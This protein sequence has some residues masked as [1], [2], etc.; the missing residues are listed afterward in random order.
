M[1][2]Q[3]CNEKSLVGTCIQSLSNLLNRADTLHIDNFDVVKRLV[4]AISLASLNC[5]HH[6]RSSHHLQFRKMICVLLSQLTWAG[7]QADTQC[8]I[9]SNKQDRAAAVHTQDVTGD[10]MP[11]TLAAAASAGAA[12]NRA[13]LTR[14]KTV[15][16]LSNL[17]AKSA[18][19][20]GG[21]TSNEQSLVS[22]TKTTMQKKH[23]VDMDK[24]YWYSTT[25]SMLAQAIGPT[26]HASVHSH[27]QHL[28]DWPRL[29]IGHRQKPSS[30][31]LQVNACS[32]VSRTFPYHGVGTV[33]MKN[34]LPFVLGPLLAMDSV[35]G[36]SCRRALENSSPNSAP[37]MLAPPVPSP[38]HR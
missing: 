30:C 16:L 35:K 20:S 33:V 7:A 18:S 5:Q 8:T 23:R 24:S 32:S 27:C 19:V 6:I 25:P 36:R 17:Q 29:S 9:L 28:A 31:T 15:C 10:R 12:M 1:C 13:G 3:L 11:P 21:Y 22:F 2:Q 14:P 37:Q 38:A 26:T 34:W 4:I